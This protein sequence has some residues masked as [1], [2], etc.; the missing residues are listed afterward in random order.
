MCSGGP[1]LRDTPTSRTV[2][3][4][5]GRPAP[6]CLSPHGLDPPSSRPHARGEDQKA[7]V[8]PRQR[9]NSRLRGHGTLGA[10]GEAG[11]GSVVSSVTYQE[12]TIPGVCKLTAQLI[13]SRSRA[14]STS[15]AASSA[16]RALPAFG[17][18]LQGQQAG[19]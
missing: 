16:Q 6:A 19:Y 3:E 14:L 12:E 11:S 17:S 10:A 4:L 5:G 9:A 8:S 15:L 7:E 1:R 18:K 13:R 2:A